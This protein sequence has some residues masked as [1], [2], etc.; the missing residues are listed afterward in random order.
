MPNPLTAKRRAQD[1]PEEQRER[2]IERLRRARALIGSTDMLFPAMEEK[3]VPESGCPLGALRSEHQQRR[4]LVTRLAE[5][6][7]ALAVEK[8]GAEGDIAET[9]RKIGELYSSHIWKEDE[10]VF[11]MVHRLKSD[12]ERDD[13][14]R[15]FEKAEAEIGADHE[16]LAAFA[17]DLDARC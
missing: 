8:P 7:E 17:D 9:V 16:E 1:L 13:L 4:E 15:G 2:T 10:M 5:S 12:S 6:T 11:P 3:G 14:F